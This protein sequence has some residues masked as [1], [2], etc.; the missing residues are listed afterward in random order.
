MI[1]P[2]ERLR[3]ANPVVDLPSRPA[4]ELWRRLED[5]RRPEPQLSRSRPLARPKRAAHRLSIGGIM[6][7]ISTLTV[8]AIAAIAFGLLGHSRSGTRAASRVPASNPA[9]PGRTALPVGSGIRSPSGVDSTDPGAAVLRTV[10][11]Q[12]QTGDPAGGLAWAMRDF[13]TTAG[14]TCLQAGRFQDQTIGVIGQDGAWGNDHRFHPIDPNATAADFCA[15]TDGNGHAFENVMQAS[16]TASGGA[17]LAELRFVGCGIAG[18]RH[19]DPCRKADLRVLQYG[20]LGPDAV[21][22]TYLGPTGRSLT[23][24]TTGPDG[25]YLIVER[26]TRYACERTW[27]GSGCG[28]EAAAGGLSAGSS[29]SAG[30]VT[31]VQYRDGRVCQVPAPPPA[32]TPAGTPQRS[33]P[34]VG[35][36]APLT[37]HPTAADLTA[38]VSARKLPGRLLVDIAFTARVAVTSENSYYEYTLTP[39]S[40]APEGCSNDSGENTLQAFTGGFSPDPYIRAGQRVVLQDQIKAGCRGTLSGTVAY[41]PNIG[42]QG[43]EYPDGFISQARSITV[44]HF[45]LTIP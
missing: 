38:P 5:G 11:L 42:P 1:D 26:A 15:E 8:L 22:I 21:S 24:P 12:V 28:R 33:C 3:A 40:T 43:T 32:S 27:S 20:L 2:I 13:Q 16:E 44:G 18:A 23:E 31:S 19:A 34:P 36:Q 41:V 17:G 6:V 9:R 4:E 39:T 37:G 35:Y 25:A 7:G 30:L 29:L 10:R 45:S 14:E